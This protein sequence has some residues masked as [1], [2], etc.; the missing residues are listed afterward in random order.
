MRFQTDNS[1]RHEIKVYTNERKS[2]MVAQE[3][4]PE[5][6]R[7]SNYIG[8]I[9]VSVKELKLHLQQ[10]G[11]SCSDLRKSAVVELCEK[12]QGIGLEVVK[13]PDDCNSSVR[14]RQTVVVDGVAV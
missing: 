7:S 3:E 2:S 14:K 13:T 5:G 11:T 1:G 6:V 12:S 9:H 4:A 8:F 10:R